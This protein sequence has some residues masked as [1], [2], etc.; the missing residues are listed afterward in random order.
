MFCDRLPKG[1]GNENI[2]L[3]GVPLQTILPPLEIS[4]AEPLRRDRNR[5]EKAGIFPPLLPPDASGSVTRPQCFC[6]AVIGSLSKHDVDGS[7]NVI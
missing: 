6:R 7:D 5:G 1:F 3:R 4:P 2:S